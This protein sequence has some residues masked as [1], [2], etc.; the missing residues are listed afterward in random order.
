M[1]ALLLTHHLQQQKQQQPAAAAD[2]GMP[3]PRGCCVRLPCPGTISCS[4]QSKPSTSAS[5]CS[6]SPHH[7]PGIG[8]YRDCWL[9]L[10]CTPTCVD[11]AVG[12]GRL[13]G[14]MQKKQKDNKTK[15]LPWPIPVLSS[16]S[17]PPLLPQECVGQLRPR[18]HTG[19]PRRL[20]ARVQ[21]QLQAD[22]EGRGHKGHWAGERG[23]QPAAER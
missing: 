9:P 16:S 22:G 7:L 6:A 15:H 20:C 2:H 18:D 13:P 10:A 21:V 19:G 8:A 1:M 11:P 17:P 3:G 14:L 4:S 23:V 5:R 12:L